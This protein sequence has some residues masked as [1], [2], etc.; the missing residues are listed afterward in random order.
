MLSRCL[1]AASSSWNR[2]AEKV[3]S[4]MS[5]LLLW[6]K[7]LP[8]ICVCQVYNVAFTRRVTSIV[9]SRLRTLARSRVA[10]ERRRILSVVPCFRQLHDFAR[11]LRLACALLRGI[12]FGSEIFI[13]NDRSP[14]Q[15][16]KRSAHDG[17]FP[18]ERYFAIQGLAV[19]L[20]PAAGSIDRGRGRT[21]K[22]RGLRD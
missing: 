7:Y 14:D 6:L 12:H 18:Q 8:L 10:R 17:Q 9:N 13:P 3:A 16:A 1:R 21:R 19:A 11:E 2:G 20:Q 15:N 5:A 22:A 4:A